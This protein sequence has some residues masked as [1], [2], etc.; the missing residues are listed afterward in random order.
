MQKAAGRAGLDAGDVTAI[1]AKIGDVGG[2]VE[3]DVRLVGAL[4]QAQAPVMHRL[5]L[6]VRLSMGE[7]APTGP[8]TERA[9]AAALKLLRS[10]S[11][12][13]ELAAAPGQLAQ[14][15]DMLH[16]AGIAA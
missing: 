16:T 1:Q 7:A 2:L 11:V 6:L 10:D 9:R 4:L 3:A 13:A 15:R 5:N 14:V 8:A 12:R